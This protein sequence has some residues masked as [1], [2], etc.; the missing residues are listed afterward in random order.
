MLIFWK[1]LVRTKWMIPNSSFQYYR[2][3]IG[4]Y[5]IAGFLMAELSTPFYAIR[6]ILKIVSNFVAQLILTF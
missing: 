2:G 3:P 1:V 4:M 5:F 6:N